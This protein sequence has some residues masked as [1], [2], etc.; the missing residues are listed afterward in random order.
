MHKNSQPRFY[1]NGNTY[2]I[3]AKT[4]QNW[5]YFRETILCDL[6]I[7]ELKNCKKIKG[8]ELFAF[9]LNYDHFH[10]LIRPNAEAN[11]SNVMQS[12]KRNFSRDA[13][14]IIITTEGDI[15]QCRLTTQ[16]RLITK[17]RRITGNILHDRIGDNMDCRLQIY[18]NRLLNKYGKN[19]LKFPQFRWQKSFHDHVIRD[20]GDAEN[21]YHYTIYN[22]L[23]HKLPQDWLYTSLNFSSLCEP[24]I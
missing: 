9:A 17:S 11:I 23:K 1:N 18:R 2:F 19:M 10:L 21:H 24:I 14:K 6:F 22:Y 15:P 5:P 13:N 20:Q 16:C 3:T 7:E 12:L 4:N 8:F